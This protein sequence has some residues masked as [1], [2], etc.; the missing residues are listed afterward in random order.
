MVMSRKN[1]VYGLISFSLKVMGWLSN[2]FLTTSGQ[3]E[4]RDHQCSFYNTY[5]FENIISIGFRY[6]KTRK[7]PYTEP[8][9]NVDLGMLIMQ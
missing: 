9:T 6:N 4:V 1:Q 8:N 2:S 5:T 3:D 7:I